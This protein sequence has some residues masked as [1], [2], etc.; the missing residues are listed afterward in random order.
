[1]HRNY[2]FRGETGC[3]VISLSAINREDAADGDQ[4]SISARESI[5][6]LF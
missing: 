1:M 3:K 5:K 4:K 2:N 6:L